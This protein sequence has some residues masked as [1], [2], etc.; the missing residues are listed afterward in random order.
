M[1]DKESKPKGT[2]AKLMSASPPLPSQP[3][4]IN[5]GEREVK[6]GDEKR[7]EKEPLAEDKKLLGARITR[8]QF[9]VFKKLYIKLNSNDSDEKI[10]K[11][12]ILGL[13]I[14]TLDKLVGEADRKFAN[15]KELTSYLVNKLTKNRDR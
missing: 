14:E 4:Q 7:K 12:E 5:K 10:D 8:S 3:M 9:A 13:A 11:G 6:S 15:S 2:F 1:P